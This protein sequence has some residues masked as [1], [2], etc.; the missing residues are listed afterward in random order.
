MGTRFR[1]LPG[2]LVPV[3]LGLSACSTSRS[4]T[5]SSTGALFVS[6]QGD[7]LVSAYT[8]DL[9]SG[10]LSTNGAGVAT[11]GVPSAMLLAPSGDALFIA[12]SA[13]NNI[14]TYTVKSDGTLTAGS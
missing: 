4:S 5:S 12:N 2:L 6:T 7:S 3:L 13:T 10:V 1:F 9:S 14:S 11:G 8:I